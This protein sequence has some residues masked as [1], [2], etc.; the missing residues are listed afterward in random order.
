M[1]L[2]FNHVQVRKALKY[3][4]GYSFVCFSFSLTPPSLPVA[5]LFG[6]VR[7]VEFISHKVPREH[8]W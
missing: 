4:E 3:E 5:C 1:S 6:K 7:V 2:K 8:F